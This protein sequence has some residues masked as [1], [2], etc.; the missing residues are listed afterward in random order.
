[1]GG[2]DTKMGGFYMWEGLL[3]CFCSECAR[4]HLFLSSFFFLACAP[5]RM[6]PRSQ[7]G[8][9]PGPHYQV[10]GHVVARRISRTLMSSRY[11]IVHKILQMLVRTKAVCKYFR[12]TKIWKTALTTQ[13][14]IYKEKI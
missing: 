9:V 4:F 1:M 2:G 7:G 8:R 11:F 6:P 14:L 12:K 13:D 10:C 5:H 3:F